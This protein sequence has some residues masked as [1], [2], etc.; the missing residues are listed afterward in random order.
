MPFYFDQPVRDQSVRSTVKNVE[1]GTEPRC[2]LDLRGPP[3]PVEG[4]IAS[5]LKQVPR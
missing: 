5:T 1:H 3:S 4:S 2:Q